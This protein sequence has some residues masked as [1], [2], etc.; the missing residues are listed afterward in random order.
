M[1]T[2]IDTRSVRY[3]I[4]YSL[5]ITTAVSV[6]LL[7]SA[8]SVHATATKVA[9]PQQVIKDVSTQLLQILEKEQALLKKD[10][11]QVYA[12]ANEVL[13]PHV[14]FLRVS[15]LV[16][17]KHWKRADPEQKEKFSGQFQRL[18]V[19]TYSSALNEFTGLEIRYLPIR[20][21]TDDVSVVVRTEVMR[22][23]AES[24]NVAYQMHK[25]GNRWMAY[26]IKIDGISL[27]TNYRNSFS[28]QVR[29]NGMDALIDN[30]TRMNNKRVKKSI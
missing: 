5:L 10:P 3:A 19:R 2:I 30:L 11:A 28:R 26:D 24:V 20:M 15:N 12:L 22:S 9:G 14:D 23:G 27:V 13:V 4:I 16:L 21:N 8:I 6:L 25:T 7:I 18:L 29:Q 1:K 17:G